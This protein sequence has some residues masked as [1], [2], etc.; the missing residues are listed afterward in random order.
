MTKPRVILFGSIGIA[1]KCLT[2]IILK[3]DI[4][5]LGACC[6]PLEDT[7]RKNEESVYDYC[8]ENNIPILEMSDIAALRPDVGFS[9]RFNQIIPA[10]VISAFKL[11]IFNTHGGILPQY[12][13]VYSNINAL[14]EGEQYYGVTLHYVQQGIDDGDIV[15]IKKVHIEDDDTGFTLYKQGEELCYYVLSENIDAILDGSN[16]RISQ[17]ELVESG[18]KVGVYTVKST[19]KKKKVDLHENDQERIYRVIRAFDSPHHEPAY[20]YINGKK[21][22]LR[23]K[24]E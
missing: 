14:I 23:A 8:L 13:G 6:V 12:R 3:R 2:E 16:E 22:Y 20:T 4:D 15:A 24:W 1:R 18:Q 17:Q 7:W 19:I 9:V 5:F 21:V 11:G 10:D